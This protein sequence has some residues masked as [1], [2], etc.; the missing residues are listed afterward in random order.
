MIYFI[1]RCE[2]AEQP[3]ES[4]T[5]IPN[6]LFFFLY[7]L[8]A[9]YHY[10][11]QCVAVH[12]KQFYS[13]GGCEALAKRMLKRDSLAKSASSWEVASGRGME[14]TDV[15]AVGGTPFAMVMDAAREDV[16]QLE[17]YF[18]ETKK[19]IEWLRE[20][21]PDMLP[22]SSSSQIDLELLSPLD[23]LRLDLDEAHV[24]GATLLKD[25]KSGNSYLP[26]L[27]RIMFGPTRWADGFVHVDELSPLS[28]SNGLFSANIYLQLPPTGKRRVSEREREQVGMI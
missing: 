6:C 28:E 25:K 20:L 17:K 13:R 12:V 4:D 14:S 23:K 27:G 7:N 16:T 1:I 24:K 19:E 11:S 18:N 10:F 3:F 2:P 26:G 5:Y 8:S 9:T 22:A 21:S 15:R